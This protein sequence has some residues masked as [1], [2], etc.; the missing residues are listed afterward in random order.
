MSWVGRLRKFRIP[1]FV[2]TEQAIGWGSRLSTDEHVLL[3]KVQRALS[4]TALAQGDLQEMVDLATQS[5]LMR[6]A[7]EAFTSAQKKPEASRR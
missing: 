1:T 5:Q 6:E 3:V 2:S 7:A 4:D